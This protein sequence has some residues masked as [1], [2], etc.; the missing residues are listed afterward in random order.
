MYELWW[1]AYVIRTCTPS[2]FFGAI[3]TWDHNWARGL[4]TNLQLGRILKG[5]RNGKLHFWASHV[6]CEDVTKCFVQLPGKQRPSHINGKRYDGSRLD[7]FK[8]HTSVDSQTS[9]GAQEPRGLTM[10]EDIKE[11]ILRTAPSS[12]GGDAY[13]YFHFGHNYYTIMQIGVTC[14]GQYSK[15]S[16]LAGSSRVF[17]RFLNL[18]W[19][20]VQ[21]GYEQA[22]KMLSSYWLNDQTA[23]WTSWR[24]WNGLKLRTQSPFFCQVIWAFWWSR[25]NTYVLSS[26]V[27]LQLGLKL[28]E[29]NWP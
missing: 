9:I 21:S 17:R 8:V 15:N 12:E 3:S 22:A 25:A 7:Q 14:H 5:S 11:K 28:I 29:I 4:L 27:T 6:K 23:T 18:R 20:R 13:D 26:V 10:N 2:A 19:G 16:A 1:R 24:S